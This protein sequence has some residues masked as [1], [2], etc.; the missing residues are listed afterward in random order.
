MLSFINCDYVSFIRLKRDISERGRELIGV[1]Q[2][3]NTFVKP[4]SCERFLHHCAVHTFGLLVSIS[5]S[6]R[7]AYF[8]F[9]PLK[10]TSRQV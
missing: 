9:S 2:Q 8:A 4:V 7:H 5:Q 3:Y 6:N 10:N 1:L